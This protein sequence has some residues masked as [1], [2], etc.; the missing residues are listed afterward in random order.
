MSSYMVYSKQ[1]NLNIETVRTYS[2]SSHRLLYLEFSARN[3][4]TVL[5]FFSICSRSSDS[6]LSS[7]SS[8]SSK[9]PS[10]AILPENNIVNF[11]QTISFWLFFLS[12][13]PKILSRWY[14]LESLNQKSYVE[15]VY[16]N[17][18]GNQQE[19]NIMKMLVNKKCL[20][21]FK[22]GPSNSTP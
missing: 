3:C 18:L 1:K 22:V 15:G 8:L 12:V 19:T 21:D 9:L 5:L 13:L 6:R 20:S 14:L 4:F 10:R 17:C 16:Q 2:S 7:W 11:D